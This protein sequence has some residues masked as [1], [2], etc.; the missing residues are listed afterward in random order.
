M[1]VQKL[2]ID[3]VLLI[4]NNIQKDNRGI[5]VKPFTN[6]VELLKDLNLGVK[7]IYYT[8]S[9]KNVIRGMH[10]QIPHMEHAKL[11]YL[12]SGSITDLL[13]DLRKSSKTFMSYISIDLLEHRNALYIPPGIAHGFLSKEDGTTIIYNQ[14]QVYSQEHDNGILWSSFG[15][16]W[17]IKNPVISDRDQSFITLD[18]FNSPFS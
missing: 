14:S 13:L 4:N 10:F 12:S 15:Y 5:F 18:E 16:S 3:G 6:I 2:E 1:N 9:K 7:E 8:I 11:I 17:G